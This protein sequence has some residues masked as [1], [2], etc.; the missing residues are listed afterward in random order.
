MDWRANFI[1]IQ[2]AL[3]LSKLKS[4]SDESDLSDSNDELLTK[5]FILCSMSDWVGIEIPS[6]ADSEFS[7]IFCFLLDSEIEKSVFCFDFSP[8]LMTLIPI[9][10]SSGMRNLGSLYYYVIGPSTRSMG[11]KWAWIIGFTLSFRSHCQTTIWLRIIAIGLIFGRRAFVFSN[12]DNFS[13]ITMILVRWVYLD[14]ITLLLWNFINCEKRNACCEKG[15]LSRYSAT[16]AE[17]SLVCSPLL[18][19]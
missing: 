12:F 15:L 7:I 19:L 5:S 18:I 6:T 4:E 3:L 8:M 14:W 9:D 13:L 11:C 16:I 1:V 10:I 17:I 2:I